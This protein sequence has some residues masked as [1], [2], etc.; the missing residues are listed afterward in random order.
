[1]VETSCY[2]PIA[3]WYITGKLVDSRSFARQEY[4]PPLHRIVSKIAA[5][6]TAAL[7]AV[8]DVAMAL[9]CIPTYWINAE[10]C[11]TSRLS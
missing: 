5:H 3:Q 1:M 2:P 11:T 10:W 6:V 8:N 4:P 7:E 9:R